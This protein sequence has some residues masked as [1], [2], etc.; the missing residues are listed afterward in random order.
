MS[1]QQRPTRERLATQIEQVF[2][3]LRPQVYEASPLM[4]LTLP[5]LRTLFFLH[6][7]GPIRM[8]EISS[9]LGVGMPTVTSLVSKLEDRGLVVREHDIKDRRVVFC[10]TT[11]LGKAEVERFWRVRRERINKFI[12]LLSEEEAELVA[13]A[14]EVILRAIERWQN[15]WETGSQ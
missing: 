8:S 10:S 12:D 7:Q 4:Q 1:L 14:N 11:E 13:Q 9:H 5:Q 15:T 3:S 2:R 6:A